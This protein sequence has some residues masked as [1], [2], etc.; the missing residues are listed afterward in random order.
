MRGCFWLRA[1]CHSSRAVL[2]AYAGMFLGAVNA[3]QIGLGSPRVCGD[4]SSPHRDIFRTVEFSPRMRGC[5]YCF[6]RDVGF[7][8]VLPAYA[9]MF[10]RQANDQRAVTKFS[11][12]M[13]GCF[14]STTFYSKRHAVLPAYAGMF[15]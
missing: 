7:T 1:S 12:R 3:F 11:P 15:L 5:F 14:W 9:G 10:L 13:R 8:Q 6:R 4:V 2:P